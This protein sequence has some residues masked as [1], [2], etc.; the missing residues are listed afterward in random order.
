MFVRRRVEL[1]GGSILL[2]VVLVPAVLFFPHHSDRSYIAY[3]Y[4]LNFASGSGLLYNP[5]QSPALSEAAAPLYTLLLGIGALLVSDL[6]ALSNALGVVAIVLGGLAL[7]G[8][9]RPAGKITALLAA[10]IYMLFPLLW[11]SLGLE[12]TT[13]MA[14]NLGALWL[15]QNQRGTGAAL[16]L[17]PA[18]LMRLETVVL[19]VI[20]IADSLAGGRPFQF[21]PTSVY[22]TGIVLGEMWA[23]AA[24]QSGGFLLGLPS[25]LLAPVL[26]D[27]IGVNVWAGLAALGRMFLSPIWLWP[28]LMCGL[29]AFCLGEQ[30]WAILLIG[31]ALLHMLSLAVL[32]VGVYTWTFA[33]LVPALA[34]LGA[35]GM[36]QGLSRTSRLPYRWAPTETATECR[37]IR[38]YRYL[39]SSYGW[40]AAGLAIALCVIPVLFLD[41][42]LATAPPDRCPAREALAPAP[43]DD[44][45]IQTGIWLRENTPVDARVG[46]TRIGVLGYLS[47]RSLIDYHGS[48][49]P[50]VAEALARG[51]SQWWLASIEPEYVVLTSAELAS[52]GGYDFT[53]DAWFTRS[54]AEVVR[55]A[56][57]EG[58]SEPLLVFRRMSSPPELL[59]IL[60]NYVT[61]PNGLTVNGIA[62]DFPLFPLEGGHEGLIRLEWLVNQTIEEP[63]FVVIQI[64]GRGEGAVA[65][66]SS[67][68]IDFSTWPHRRLITTYHPIEI[69]SGLPPGVY[70]IQIGIGPDAYTLTRQTVGQAKV[71]FQGDD[72][73]GGIS[74]ARTEFGD[75]ALLGYRLA[76]TEN[77]LELLLLWEAVHIPQADYRVFVHVRDQDGAVITQNE[78]EP[79]NGSYPTSIWSVGEQVPDVYLLDISDVPPGDYQ[80]YIGLLDPDDTRILALDGRD[81]LF[82]GQ[83]NVMP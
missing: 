27:I 53:R 26:P 64:Q 32:Q 18:T 15:H 28:A 72:L 80:V 14:L 65:G 41:F 36:W 48:L 57:P 67:R 59:E 44:R 45:Y 58:N 5:G 8:L 71:P 6:P 66:L 82:V 47:Q 83:V 31:W 77:G 21:V 49:Q 7:Y 62:A 74:G 22:V 17:V 39:R 78:F 56:G 13:W 29:G 70:D 61:Y 63:Q 52:L 24:Y 37:Y 60:I 55:F 46:A 73:L 3:R 81:A 2:L 9:A 68:E 25:M 16:L 54:Y 33:P 10:G 79:H 12:T 23:L 69:A 4:A 76:R 51:D 11:L 75:I 1:I 43:A 40:I 38:Q 34:A 42:N 50:N 30:R 19:V 20:L 35:L